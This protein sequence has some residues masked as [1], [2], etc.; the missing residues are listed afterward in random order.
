MTDEQSAFKVGGIPQ[1]DPLSPAL[2]I[3]VCDMALTHARKTKDKGFQLAEAGTIPE[4]PNEIHIKCQGYADD[5]LSIAATNEE[6]RRTTQA[7]VDILAV[8]NIRVQGKKCI[9]LRSKRAVANDETA[10]PDLVGL[11]V[12]VE[13]EEGR[14]KHTSKVGKVSP[15]KPK[16]VAFHTFSYG[17]PSVSKAR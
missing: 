1:G 8:L 4:R 16:R 5:L 17:G 2:W 12:R 10:A 14:I 9:Y 13:G 7:M 15:R 11:P 3:V 6:A